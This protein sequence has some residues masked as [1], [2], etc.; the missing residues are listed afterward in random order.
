MPWARVRPRHGLLTESVMDK[1]APQPFGAIGYPSRRLKTI[2]QQRQSAILEEEVRGEQASL[3]DRVLDYLRT[4]YRPAWSLLMTGQVPSGDADG[5][6]DLNDLIYSLYFLDWPVQPGPACASALARYLA[7]FRLA[8]GL[9]G[10]EGDV[11]VSVHGTAYTLGALTLLEAQGQDLL[12][13]VMTPTTWRWDELF[14]VKTS[15]PRWPS[16]WS[17]HNWRVSHWIGGS[18][19]ILRELSH[20][21]PEACRTSGAPSIERALDASDRLIDARTGILK[22]YRSRLLQMAFRQAYR[23]RHDPLLGDIGGVVHVHWVNYAENRSFKAGDRLFE[24]SKNAM[25]ARRPFMESVPYCLDFDVVQI[26]RTAM[27]TDFAKDDRDALN[28]RASAYADDIAAFLG[29][30]LGPD[31]ALHKLPGALATIHECA[32]ID[33]SISLARLGLSARDDR[34]KDIMKDT[35]WL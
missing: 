13:A 32:L 17:H 9:N 20:H 14:D 15:L 27:P 3:S 26:V 25:L 1:V 33:P 2:M 35:S 23:L 21:M 28:R 31:Y 10:D 16:K 8:G 34:P 19:S 7:S 30:N 29:A 12:G 22:C 4:H 6:Q 5:L 11:P 24:R 18:L